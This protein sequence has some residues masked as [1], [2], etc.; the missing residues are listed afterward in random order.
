MFEFFAPTYTEV[1]RNGNGWVRTDRPLLYNYVFVKASENDIYRMM[2]SGLGIYS[3]LPRVRDGRGGHYPYLSDK[4]MD[5][6]KWVARSYSDVLPV[7]P[8][9]PEYLLKGDRVRITDGQFKDA[10]ATVWSRS[11]TGQKEVVVCVE[12]WLCVNIH[13]RQLQPQAYRK[14]LERTSFE[15]GFRSNYSVGYLHSLYGYLRIAS[16]QKTIAEVAREY[17]VTQYYLQHR[18]FKGTPI[19]YE[20]H[21][22]R[23]VAN[24]EEDKEKE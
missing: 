21:I 14:M 4:A 22:I 10:E 15:L 13:G 20:D 19:Q 24:I 6:L 3:F 1:T 9:K 23:Q 12:D 17:G 2:T 5:N 16:G 8:M 18:I 7:C 11:G